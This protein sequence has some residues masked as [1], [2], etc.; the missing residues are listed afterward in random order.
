MLFDGMLQV[1]CYQLIIL[2]LSQIHQIEKLHCVE[3]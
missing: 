1:K 3:K 2:K